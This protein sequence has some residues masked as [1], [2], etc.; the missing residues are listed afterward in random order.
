MPVRLQ[1][2]RGVLSAGERALRARIHR[3][4]EAMLALLQLK[5]AE[6]SLVLSSD[7]QIHDLNRT[8]R[9]KDKPTDV[10]A[11]SMREGDFGRL[12]AGLPSHLLGDVIVAIPTAKRQAKAARRDLLAEVTMLVGHGLLHLLGWDHETPAKDAKMRAET[13]R[14]IACAEDADAGRPTRSSSL[15]KKSK[16]AKKT[17]AA[18][19]GRRAAKAA[20]PEMPRRAR[21]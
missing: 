11:F 13:N 7:E 5:N 19:S 20:K 2:D 16:K 14:L 4:A 18:A 1:V 15:S 10:L 17:S 8:Y 12:H 21:R 6:L 3:R 9:G